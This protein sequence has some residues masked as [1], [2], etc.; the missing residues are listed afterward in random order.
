MT[1]TV[2]IDT[3]CIS[4]FLWVDEENIL[5]KL[6]SDIIIPKEVYDELSHPGLNRLK[7]MKEQ[8]DVLISQN[9]IQLMHIEY[10]S[11]AYRLYE[12]LSRYPKKGHKV[13]GKGEASAISL[14]KTNNG[15]IASNNLKDIMSYV[16]E[17]N[18][19]YLTTGDIMKM[20]LEKGYINIEQGEKIW[21]DM[22]NKRR[23]L[24]YPTFS[25]FLKKNTK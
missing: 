24:G 22:L 13:I 19:E 21:S 8:I 25:D 3:D 16:D 12:Q 14:A 2:F 7:G 9:Q 23:K 6:F 18:L 1:K 4:A 5:T 11:E 10:G 17:Y 20:A 15:I